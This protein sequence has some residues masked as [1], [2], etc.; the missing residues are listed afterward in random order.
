MATP[1]TTRVGAANESYNGSTWDF[2]RSGISAAVS[3]FVGF[4]N[5]LPY[6]VYRLVKLTLTDGQGV[7]LGLESNGD[8]RIAEQRAAVAELNTLGVIAVANRPLAGSDLAATTISAMAAAGVVVKGSAGTLYRVI[9]TNG[10]GATRYLQ[11]HNTA[12]A[13][14]DTAVPAIT[15]SVPTLTSYILELA[16]FGRYFDTGIYVCHSSTAFTKTI[17]TTDGGF[18]CLS[19]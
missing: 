4:T 19:M 13:P 6:A 12:S 7:P 18:S 17:G 11:V 5:N 8:L 14:A 15:I 1:T 10:N 9:Y 2:I 16:P 3:T